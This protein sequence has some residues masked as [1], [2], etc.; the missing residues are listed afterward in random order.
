[1]LWLAEFGGM[2]DL[3]FRFQVCAPPRRVFVRSPRP[4]LPGTPNGSCDEGLGMLVAELI[5]EPGASPGTPVLASVALDTGR[6]IR[7]ALDWC[8]DATNVAP[9]RILPAG[10]IATAAQP[11]NAS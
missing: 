3:G 4:V 11:R 7:V 9:H 10:R 8:S 1:M 5:P 2:D 6:T